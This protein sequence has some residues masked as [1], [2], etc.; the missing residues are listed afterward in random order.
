[1]KLVDKLVAQFLSLMKRKYYS[2]TQEI[3]AF[4]WKLETS[5]KYKL[6]KIKAI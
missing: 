1:M 4:F 6:K 2:G 3:W 5:R